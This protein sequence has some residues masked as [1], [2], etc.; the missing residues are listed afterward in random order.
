MWRR[1]SSLSSL[2]LPFEEN[3]YDR[4]AR[5]AKE[6]PEERW[7]LPWSFEGAELKDPNLRYL[8]DRLFL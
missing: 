1:M 6:I 2:A 4:V 7:G 3:P 8:S 5:L